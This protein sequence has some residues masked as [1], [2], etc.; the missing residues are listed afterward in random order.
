MKTHHQLVADLTKNDTKKKAEVRLET[1]KAKII[2]DLVEIREQLDL[3]Q[4]DI[5]RRLGMTQQ[6][7]SR[8]ENAE[9]VTID[10]LL[11]YMDGLGTIVSVERAKI[12]RKNSVLHFIEEIESEISR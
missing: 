11:R 1:L 6:M 5:A 7:I 8:I 2:E 3:T 12:S 4:H 9:N 10:T